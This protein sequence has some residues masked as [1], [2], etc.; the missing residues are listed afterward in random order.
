MM[1]I[2]CTD[3]HCK[4]ADPLQ[5][6]VAAT[7]QAVGLKPRER[8]VPDLEAWIGETA[9]ASWGHTGNCLNE[10]C[11]RTVEFKVGPDG[12]GGEQVLKKCVQ[13]R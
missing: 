3:L 5:G 1:Y 2:V 13:Y 9:V 11:T 10:N 8:R 6:P 12:R 7:G 4:C